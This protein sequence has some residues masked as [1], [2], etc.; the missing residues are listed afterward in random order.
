MGTLKTDFKDDI[1]QGNRKYL[2]VKNE[3]GT[4]SF[5]DATQYEQE[6]DY[7]G[8][9]EIN[10]LSQAVNEA[11]QSAS[12]GKEAIKAAITG[13]DPTVTIP[14]DATFAQLADAIGQI[15]TGV[16]TE[17]A[18][19]TAE[20]ILAGL[21]AYVKGA[22][23]TGT[24]VNNGP[25]SAETINITNQ[26]QEYTI[27]KGFHSGLRKIKAVITNL[28]SGNIRAGVSVGGVQGK[29]TVVDTE[30]A[31]L[32]PAYLLTGYSGYDDGIKKAGTM[33]NFYGAWQAA[34]STSPG[35][36]RLHM[37]PPTG[38]YN[39]GAG[40]GVYADSAD[41]IAANILSGKN[42]FG[43]AGTAIAG[44]RFASGSFGPSYSGSP[45]VNPGASYLTFYDPGGNS[46]SRAFMISISNLN[47]GFTP[48]LILILNNLYS[49][50]ANGVTAYLKDGFYT[51]SGATYR[52]MCGDLMLRSLSGSLEYIPIADYGTNGN[53]TWYAW[54]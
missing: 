1:Y 11:F 16:D 5:S 39:T 4:V 49:Y 43:V 54:E 10:A 22:K 26:N 28:V 17:D 21:T 8:A 2:Q 34:L 50:T 52:F 23:V 15:E 46:Y 40:T 7:F 6:G 18:T 36:G 38:Y 41:F 47:L 30:D 33:P 44:K 25:A 31:V 12:N 13:I 19:A 14:T 29:S 32:D 3:D 51:S 45:W 42:I 53:S 27:A 37:F 20:Y 35:V 24:G 48:S 9:N